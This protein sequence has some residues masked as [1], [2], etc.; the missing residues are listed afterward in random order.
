MSALL[1][2][3]RSAVADPS[4]QRVITVSGGNTY[5][6]PFRS[7]DDVRLGFVKVDARHLFVVQSHTWSLSGF[8]GM[9]RSV[10]GGRH[11]SEMTVPPF[12]GDGGKSGD[13]VFFLT[14]NIGW[15]ISRGTSGGPTTEYYGGADMWRTN[16]GGV[17]WRHQ[18]NFEDWARECPWTVRFLDKRLGFAVFNYGPFS[19]GPL[20]GTTDGGETWH[21]LADFSKETTCHAL[22][23]RGSSIE[24]SC[25][26]DGR[27]RIWRRIRGRWIPVGHTVR[28]EDARFSGSFGWCVWN[29]QPS[30]SA[31]TEP[32]WHAQIST[33]YGATWIDVTSSKG[34]R[35]GQRERGIQMDA[36]SITTG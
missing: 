27:F 18:C 9:F 30:T 17:S 19:W 15:V 23:R 8:I 33:D 3:P 13:D 36:Q 26:T 21:N 1:V 28:A 34:C 4:R 7:S 10:D 31:S 20:R 35:N 32:A 2:V 11:W 24:A 6:V 5:R 16:N 25:S 29:R 12:I 14:P 22:R